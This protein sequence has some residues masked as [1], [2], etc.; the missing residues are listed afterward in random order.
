MTIS[1]VTDMGI[2]RFVV[3]LVILAFNLNQ[4]AWAQPVARDQDYERSMARVDRFMTL[5]EELRSHVDRSQ[6]DTE[7]L[8]EK[9]DY[10]ETNIVAFVR[11]EI[12]FEQYPGLL[13]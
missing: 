2:R 6:F 1:K 11:D 5:L 12:G 9:L 3:W 10:D 4:L 8:L 13:R 7:A